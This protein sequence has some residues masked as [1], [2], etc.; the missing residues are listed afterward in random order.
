MRIFLIILFIIAS[1]CK[2]NK[3]SKNHGFISLE[4]KFEKI[5][6]NKTNKNDLIKTIGHP[7]SISEFDENKWF[8]IER[9]KTNQS[10][11]KLGIKKIN[12]NNILIVDFNNKG[13]VEN[14][15]LIDLNNMNDVKYV[16][17][18]TQKEFDQDNTIYNIFSSLREKINAPARNRN[19]SN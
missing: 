16:K 1:G 9:K 19:K 11:F 15:K 3:V 12:K 13:L 7:S 5:Q 6:I 4:T 18:I 14:K 8:Y 17:K 2:A 10:L